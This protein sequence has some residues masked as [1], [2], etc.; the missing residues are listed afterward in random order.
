MPPI[1]VKYVISFS[2]QAPK[3]TVED[4]VKSRGSWLSDA[5]DRTGRLQADIQLERPTT[6]SYIDLG[7][8]GSVMVSIEVG[9]SS[10]PSNK[11]LVALLPTVAL[12]TPAEW[13]AGKNSK[14]VRMFKKE[15]LDQDA[16]KEKWDRVRI[17]CTQP[18]RKDTQFGLALFCLHTTD[19][20]H[21]QE[22]VTS[23][24]PQRVPPQGTHSD[25]KKE[26]LV[27]RMNLPTAQKK[28][29]SQSIGWLEN[30]VLTNGEE[31]NASNPFTSPVS[32]AAR[33]VVMATK[34]TS[35]ENVASHK[36]SLECEALDF[37]ISLNLNIEE[38]N[39]LKVSGV[40]QQFE[41]QRQKM[42]NHDEKIIFKDIALDYAKKRLES[43]EK[44]LEKSV[45]ND[46]WK[47]KNTAKKPQKQSKKEKEN[48]FKGHV[49]K[50]TMNKD[51]KEEKR[52]TLTNTNMMKKEADKPANPHV[53]Q[54]SQGKFTFKKIEAPGS[55]LALLKKS[56]VSRT[57]HQ[58]SGNDLTTLSPSGLF[59]NELALS[60]ATV[61][62]PKRPRG[63]PKKS[64]TPKMVDSKQPTVNT[65]ITPVAKRKREEPH[66]SYSPQA[67]QF[68]RELNEVNSGLIWSDSDDDD[69]ST[70]SVNKQE[71]GGFIDDVTPWTNAN[72]QGRDITSSGNYLGSVPSDKFGVAQARKRS[73]GDSS[74][75][76]Q[77]RAS[78]QSHSSTMKECPL[79]SG[80][81]HPSKIESHAASCGIVLSSDSDSE[82]EDGYRSSNG[83]ERNKRTSMEECPVCGNFINTSDLQEHAAE[84]ANSTF[85]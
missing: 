2:S 36:A 21:V 27:S 50:T 59:R 5:S 46:T 63:R 82:S 19:E 72:P 68:S 38:I 17:I 3:N 1:R 53:R 9:R 28:V 54:H 26:E 13:R 11:P 49:Q 70:V 52:R 66:F 30:K 58:R 42:L 76:T 84:C 34:P 56:P 44:R 73:R 14:T 20:C 71:G 6:I 60:D 39:S 32:R 24:N 15:D 85:G 55:S 74:D 8:A 83:N 43:L 67:S 12:M 48:K 16:V 75:Y 81:F 4:L 57:E 40:R 45:Q 79:C 41:Q 65:W 35:K 37:L 31:A 61:T 33:L 22:E 78:S 77:S 29:M 18:F 62:T 10:W 69:I 25:L 7:N 51:N 47:N 64:V 23:V 80:F